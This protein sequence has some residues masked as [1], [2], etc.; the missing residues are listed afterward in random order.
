MSDADAEPA[1][2]GTAE[3]TRGS[4]AVK[5]HLDMLLLAILADGARHGYGVI[6]QLR[7]RSGAAFDLPEGTVYPAL[8]RLERNGLLSSDW[9]RSGG[10]PRRVYRLTPPGQARLRE[11][12][13]AWTELSS[14]ITTI[15]EGTPWPST[16]RAI[17]A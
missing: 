16:T 7:D 15:L 1:A 11:Q 13:A 4:A 14:A 17:T 8:H 5:G 10:R 6:E 9:D 2:A 3:G 12:H